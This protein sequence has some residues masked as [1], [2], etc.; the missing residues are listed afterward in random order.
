MRKNSLF[1]LLLLP[2][3]IQR[4]PIWLHCLTSRSPSMVKKRTFSGCM[5]RTFTH[6]TAPWQYISGYRIQFRAKWTSIHHFCKKNWPGWNRPRVI[7]NVISG[8]GKCW[9]S[10]FSELHWNGVTRSWN[11]YSIYLNGEFNYAVIISWTRSSISSI[12]RNYCPMENSECHLYWLKEY[13]KENSLSSLTV[14]QVL[15]DSTFNKKIFLLKELAKWVMLCI[16]C[17]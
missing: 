7:I 15:F 3:I 4:N 10:A 16:Y 1:L 11:H 17:W 12:H 14:S 9:K 2:Q 13:E 8:W 6:Q 5:Q